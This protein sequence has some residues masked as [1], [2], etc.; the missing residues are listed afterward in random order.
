ML[1]QTQ[2][3]R[4]AIVW[5][6]FMEQFPTVAMTAA[7]SPADVIAAWDRLGYPRRARR[8]WETAVIVHEY[9]W[10]ENYC[11][12]PGVGPY[13][14][15]ALAA[16]ADGDSAAIGI[17]VNIRRVAQRVCGTSLTD[18]AARTAAITIAE[19]LVGRDRLL[20]LMDLGATLCRVRDPLCNACP[21]HTQC[22]T[23][24]ALPGEARS[25]QAPYKGSLREQRGKI[26]ATLRERSIVLTTEFDPDVLA[27]DRLVSVIDGA[28]TLARD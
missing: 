27:A 25:R 5:P 7:S 23:R 12:L 24:G 14:A 18:S 15:G 26:L 2:V 17:D 10:P 22:H 28:V 16:Q 9:G 3:Q 21:L 20:A 4:V 11:D 8:L 6:R 1:A 19:P 13:T